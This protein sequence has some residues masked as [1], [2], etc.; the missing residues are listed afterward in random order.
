MDSAR[1]DIIERIIELCGASALAAAAGF[2]TWTLAPLALSSS[3]AAAAAA[4]SVTFI[5][6]YTVLKRCGGHAP[7]IG[8]GAFELR[9]IEPQP[10]PEAL[11][12]DDILASLGPD[13]RVVRMFAPDAIPTA[14]QLQARI[15]RHIASDG[16]DA[17]GDRDDEA[18]E[19]L[20]AALADIR[21]SLR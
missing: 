1:N 19:A 12:L 14:G 3:S 21:R 2:A 7:T 6:A 11:L 16:R 13:S 20:H 5:L 4:A 8:L 10:E 15:D 17:R 18:R 9:T